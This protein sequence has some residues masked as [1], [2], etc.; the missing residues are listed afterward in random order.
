MQDIVILGAGGLAREA[1]D[2]FNALNVS[3]REPLYR[4][5]GF[6][7]E[8]PDSH[9][10]SLNGI[11][12]LGSFDWL[13]AHD[14]SRMWAVSCVGAP[15][16]KLR[17]AH[18]AARWGI[19]FCT[20]VHPAST[21]TPFVS[22]GHGTIVTAGCILTNH[23]SI[24]N[25]VYLNLSCTVGH[26]VVIEDYATINPGVR[27]SGNVH[28][29]SGCEIGTGAIIIQGITIGEWS[30]VGAGAVV[31]K[32]VPPNTT[33]VGVPARVIKRRESGWQELVAKAS[34][35]YHDT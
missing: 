26:D 16:I 33:A 35:G 34:P 20:A 11:P 24:G 5:L 2:V 15:A 18:Q 13:K 8:N 30:I 12:V 19:Q 10:I 3:Q 27:I 32:D 25:H 22:L 7:D 21:V 14:P 17:L 29:G 6:I 9:G 4:V 28:I 23:I 1:L 31:V